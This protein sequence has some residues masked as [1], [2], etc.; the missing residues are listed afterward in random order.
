MHYDFPYITKLD[1]VVHLLDD[2]EEFI[3]A[4]KEHFD[5]INYNVAFKDTFPPVLCADDAI[6]REFRGLAFNKDGT[7]AS[8]PFH[9]FFNFGEREETS[10]LKMLDGPHEIFDKLDGS[11]IRPILLPDNTIYWATKMASP[12]FHEEVMKFVICS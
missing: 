12:D 5:I 11:M 3:L 1:D 4:E 7:I 8:R 10:D 9:K 6:L 2:R